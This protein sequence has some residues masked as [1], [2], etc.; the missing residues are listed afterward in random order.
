MTQSKPSQ[1]FIVGIAALIFSV[2][3]KEKCDWCSIALLG[4]FI[5]LFIWGSILQYKKMKKIK[6]LKDKNLL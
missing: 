2:K 3:V 4:A 5:I 6:R 1:L